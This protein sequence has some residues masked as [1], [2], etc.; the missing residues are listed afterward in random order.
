MCTKKLSQ[1]NLRISLIFNNPISYNFRLV[2]VALIWL[3]VCLRFDWALILLPLLWY[4]I[5]IKFTFEYLIQRYC[6]A[7]ILLYVN[8]SNNTE[9]RNFSLIHLLF[10]TSLMYF[11]SHLSLNI[12]FI[13]F[14]AILLWLMQKFYILL[15]YVI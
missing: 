14:I 7:F 4:N 3:I 12:L 11:I 5:E 8:Y 6:I 9:V 2:F 15:C 1:I 13:F 10:M